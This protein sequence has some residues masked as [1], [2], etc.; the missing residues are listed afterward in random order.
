MKKVFLFAA[1]TFVLAL[2]FAF[3]SFKF[4]R[5]TIASVYNV[6]G[7]MFSVGMGLL[8]TF[9]LDGVRNRVYIEKIR[10]NISLLEKSFIAW[11]V[12]STAIFT[13]YDCIPDKHIDLWKVSTLNLNCL[14]NC[15]TLFF[16]L[17]AIIYYVVN[18]LEVQKLNNDIFDRI[19]KETSK[20][21]QKF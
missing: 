5:N 19:N 9:K 20:D 8:V 3:L 11:F 21:K 6:S 16:I 1:V 17:V 2:V 7:I 13:F 4:D 15:F 14:A 10:N 18:F 12:V